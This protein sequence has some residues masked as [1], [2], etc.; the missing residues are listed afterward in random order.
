MTRKVGRAADT[1]STF[2]AIRPGAPVFANPLAR[3]VI[4]LAFLVLAANWIAAIGRFQVNV[5]YMDQWGFFT[6]IME[7][8]S[9]WGLFDRQHGPHRQGL[10]FLLTSGIMS[11]CHWDT[12]VDSIWICLVLVASAALGL[13][14][15]RR[16]AGP[17]RAADAWIVAAILALGQCETVIITPNASHSAFP[18]LLTLALGHIWLTAEP[19][20]R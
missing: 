2:G 15:K 18:L 12:R 11:L 1:G 3:W 16:I 5:L 10:A 13:L 19:S 6:P 4:G 8:K 7:G 14:L 20:V 17:L 9:W